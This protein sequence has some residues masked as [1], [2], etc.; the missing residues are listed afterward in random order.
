MDQDSPTRMASYVVSGVGFLGG[1][2][3][4]RDGLNVKGID[5]AATLWCSAAVG[6][7]VGSG[8]VLHG[9]AATL[10]VLAL[11]LVLRPVARWLDTW[12]RTATDMEEPGCPCRSS[13]R[14]RK[15][16]EA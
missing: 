13:A 14:S 6:T 15:P 7:L 8:F 1:G 16:L 4:L 11:N 9:L 5:T 3:I 2:I 12:F 10:T